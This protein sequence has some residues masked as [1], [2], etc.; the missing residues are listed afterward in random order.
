MHI[1]VRYECIASDM[2]A[3]NECMTSDMNA[4]YECIT[5][6]MNV[7]CHHMNVLMSNSSPL[8]SPLSYPIAN[9]IARISNLSAP[10][11]AFG[12]DM[13]LAKTQ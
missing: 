12:E 9:E 6:D 3:G 7:S 2:N 1:C 13:T 5:S 10:Y 11:A 8:S 4:G